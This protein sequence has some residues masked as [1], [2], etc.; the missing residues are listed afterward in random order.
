MRSKLQ[1]AASDWKVWLLFLSLQIPSLRALAKYLPGAWLFLI[2]LYLAGTWF[3][4]A[5]LLHEGV[6]SRTLKRFTSRGWFLMLLLLALFVIQITVYPIADALKYEGHGTPQDDALVA[7]GEYLAH[8]W[9]PYEAQTHRYEYVSAG[10]GWILL[11]LPFTLTGTIGLFNPFWLAITVVVLWRMR[12][13]FHT[14]ALFLI[15]LMS[16]LAFWEMTVNGSDMISIGCGLLLSTIFVHRAWSGL[17]PSIHGK[18]SGGW[19]WRALA[20]LLL[21]FVAT[22]RVVFAYVVP[23]LG[24]FLRHRGWKQSAVFV[25]VAGGLTLLL[26]GI[27]YF[28]NPSAYFPLHRFADV[29]FLPGI[30]MSLITA[31]ISILFLLL[32]VQH[33][34]DNLE[35]WILNLWLALGVTMAFSA[36]SDLISRSFSLS[37][38]EGANYLGILLPLFVVWQVLSGDAA[39]Q[40]V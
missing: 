35:S 33:S 26:H 3:L 17:S 20:V 8:G 27:F 29:S 9:N 31:V 38:W 39:K 28:W 4:Y 1:A 40:S 7:G 34:Q 25:A 6:V 10:P 5:D 22:S 30:T 32:A 24:G 21:S 36:L 23:L 12:K 15:L 37:Q 18:T 2:P 19:L 13:E 11:A 16:S 14:P